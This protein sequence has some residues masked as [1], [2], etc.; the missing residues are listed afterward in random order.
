MKQRVWLAA[1]TD[2][3][4]LQSKVFS[5]RI[6]AEHYQQYAKNRLHKPHLIHLR[7]FLVDDEGGLR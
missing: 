6:K 2:E 4:C 5:T 3:A 7:S 1:S